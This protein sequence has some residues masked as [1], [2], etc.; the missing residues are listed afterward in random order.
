MAIDDLPMPVVNFLNVIGVQWPYIDE[1][2]VNQF[3]SL[4]REFGQAVEQTHQDATDAVNGIASAHQ[5]QSTEALKSGWANLSCAHVTEIWL[6]PDTPSDDGKSTIK[7][8]GRLDVDP[9]PPR[10]PTGPANLP[11][12]P[13]DPGLKPEH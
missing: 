1:D 10:P 12:P 8:I 13:R 7:Y 6:S 5:G 2:A 9:A 4:V 11:R 3:A